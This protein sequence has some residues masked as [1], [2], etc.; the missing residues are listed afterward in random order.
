M[1]WERKTQL[2]KEMKESVDSEAGQAEVKAMKAEI[3]RMQVKMIENIVNNT[4]VHVHFCTCIR[5]KRDMIKCWIFHYCDVCL[6]IIHHSVYGYKFSYKLHVHV[7]VL[8]CMYST[9]TLH[10]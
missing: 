5:I 1:L 6:I 3:H 7:H 4:R 10:V 8:Q 2:A 9:C